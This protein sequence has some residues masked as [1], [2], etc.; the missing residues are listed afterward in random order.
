MVGSKFTPF[1]LNCPKHSV[2]SFNML[3]LSLNLQW[4]AGQLLP[5]AL[6]RRVVGMHAISTLTG[7]ILH[8]RIYTVY[9]RVSV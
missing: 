1:V 4:R 9:V 7:F 8:E 3:F 5:R 2:C 6:P